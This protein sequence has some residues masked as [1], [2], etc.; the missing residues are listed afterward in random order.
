MGGARFRTAHVDASAGA[1]EEVERIVAPLRAAWSAVHIIRRWDSGFCRDALLTWCETHAV[2]YVSGLAKN[3]CLTALIADERRAMEVQ[4]H[5]TG[6]AARVFTEHTYHTLDSWSCTRRVV[7]KAKHLP[8]T[9]TSKA[10]PRFVFVVTSLPTRTHDARRLYEDVYLRAGR[11]GEPHQGT[12]DS[13]GEDGGAAG[14]G[15]EGGVSA[16]KGEKGE[17]GEKEEESERGENGER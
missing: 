3:T 16:E 1:V 12:T 14:E 11:D 10:N 17:K 7:A 15:K 6:T 8:A 5:A 13:T 2:D 4:G 9:D